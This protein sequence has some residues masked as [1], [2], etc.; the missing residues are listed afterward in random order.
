MKYKTEDFI[1]NIK[2]RDELFSGVSPSRSD[3]CKEIQKICKEHG[4]LATTTE[5]EYLWELI[6]EN[7]YD[8]CWMSIKDI[9]VWDE[10]SSYLE[11]NILDLSLEQ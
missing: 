11:D 8:A 3:A 9:D 5:C 6:S 10:I 1:V 2:P 4:F 7:K